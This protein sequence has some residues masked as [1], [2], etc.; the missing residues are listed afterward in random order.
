LHSDGQRIPS[1]LVLEQCNSESEALSEE[2]R[3]ISLFR[4]NG[5][6]LVNL[7][8]GGEGVLGYKQ[9]PETIA[10]RVAKV[11]GCKH[12]KESVMRVIRFHTGRKRTEES[13]QKMREAALKRTPVSEET[14]RKLSLIRTGRKRGQCLNGGDKNLSIVGNIVLL[15]L[16]KQERRKASQ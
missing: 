14:K 8:D 9:S 7:T 15:F 4:N 10:N 6:D 1:V 5:F 12:S 13:K 11:K 3:L 2:V 16:M